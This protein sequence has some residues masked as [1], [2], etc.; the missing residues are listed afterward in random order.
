MGSGQ[1][2]HLTMNSVTALM[3]PCNTEG[4]MRSKTDAATA[5]ANAPTK[6]HLVVRTRFVSSNLEALRA[7]S[8]PTTTTRRSGGGSAAPAEDPNSAS[9]VAKEQASQGGKRSSS[10]TKQQEYEYHHQPQLQAHAQQP[11]QFYHT[12]L[13]GQKAADD[14]APTR[15]VVCADA[16]GWMKERGTVLNYEQNLAPEGA[17]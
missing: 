6:Q 13:H 4:R 15:E 1:Q 11:P 3:A 7:S 5:A 17:I 14:A 16:I 12:P 2:H 9:A 10:S 8:S